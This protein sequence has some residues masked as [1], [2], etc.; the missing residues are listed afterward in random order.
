[1]ADPAPPLKSGLKSTEFYMTLAANT[2]GAL[3]ASGLISDGGTA[4]KILGVGMIVLS[5]MGYQ[6]QRTKLKVGPAQDPTVTP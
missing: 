5:T 6:Y 1:M 4:A 3:L 2:V